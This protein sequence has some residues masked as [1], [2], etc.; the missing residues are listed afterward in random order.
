[1]SSGNVA[2][3]SICE[4]LKIKMSELDDLLDEMQK[5]YISH[6]GLR[7]QISGNK[8]CLTTAPEL[9]QVVEEFL[10]LEASSKMTRASLETLAIIVYKQPVTR[11]T[12]DSIRG[13]NSDGVIKSLLFKGLIEEI[14]RAETPGRP[15]LY[16]TTSTFL[17][18]F[19]LSNLKELPNIEEVVASVEKTEKK[20]LKD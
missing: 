3:T 8:L 7:I 20:I 15:I 6:H 5:N 19:G 12:I 18:E 2:K 14:G 13:V 1:M 17:Q 11:P 4:L 16:G 10:G 9:A